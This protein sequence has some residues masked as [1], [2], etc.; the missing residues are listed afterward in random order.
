ME[1]ESR[2]LLLVDGRL[3]P[4]VLL[5]GDRGHGT[6]HILEQLARVAHM[7]AADGLAYL[8]LDRVQL[9]RIKLV[10]LV[11]A[12][13]Q[14]AAGAKTASVSIAQLATCLQADAQVS[15]VAEPP[16]ARVVLDLNMPN[17]TR[18]RVL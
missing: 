5:V 1:D 11:P 4:L 6:A 17:N 7:E 10:A 3:H 9:S 18:D 15:L 2:R 13:A 14:F 12:Q 16:V 8:V